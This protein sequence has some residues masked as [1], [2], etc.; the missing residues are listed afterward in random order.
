MKHQEVNAS[1]I[2]IKE[3]TWIVDTGTHH[4]ADIVVEKGVRVWYTVLPQENAHIER[5]IHLQEDALF[6]GSAVC[7]HSGDIQITTDIKGNHVHATMN[8][9]AIVTSGIKISVEGISRVSL[10]YRGVFTRVD[11]TN[12][13]VGT[14][15]TV[16][17]VPRL[18]IATDDIEG[19]HSCRIHELG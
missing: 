3:D 7:V 8:I 12:I 4:Q 19:G 15:A 11:Q 17:G 1:H 18:D 16:R 9:L 5:H 6:E 13:L 14:G 2:Q 10:P